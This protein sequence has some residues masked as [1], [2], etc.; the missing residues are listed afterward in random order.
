[1]STEKYVTEKIKLVHNGI[2][3]LVT[4]IPATKPMPNGLKVPN[5]TFIKQIEASVSD[6]ISGFNG[7]TTND[8]IQALCDIVYGIDNWKEEGDILFEMVAVISKYLSEEKYLDRLVDARNEQSILMLS[9]LKG[10]SELIKHNRLINS[11]ADPYIFETYLKTHRTLQQDFIRYISKACEQI[12]KDKDR[13]K[14][15]SPKTWYLVEE[16]SQIDGLAR[17]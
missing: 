12:I 1:M 5:A 14:Y 10:T 15:L 6:I 8:S 4:D 13:Y 9:K 11:H 16:L 17:I 7:L 2:K 3:G